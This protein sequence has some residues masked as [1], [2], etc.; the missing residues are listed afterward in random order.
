VH[1]VVVPHLADDQS[2]EKKG[3]RRVR[4]KGARDQ[5]QEKK[6]ARNARPTRK[7]NDIVFLD[8]ALKDIGFKRQPVIGDGWVS[9]S[10]HP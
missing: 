5:S 1:A 3:A 7:T 4:E 2:K 6:G 8:K 10:S 9:L